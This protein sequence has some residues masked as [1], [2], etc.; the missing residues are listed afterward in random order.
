M[1]AAQLHVTPLSLV[2]IL[3]S[4]ALTACHDPAPERSLEGTW[5][6]RTEWTWDNKGE[7]IP[8]SAVQQAT[9]QDHQVQSTGTLSIG[10]AQTEP[11]EYECDQEER[12]RGRPE[13]KC[14]AGALECDAED[15]RAA[16]S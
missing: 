7:A 3:L 14:V 1:N 10:D 2:L 5:D 11:S 13:H 15:E 4:G 9:S 12:E 8:C 16:C 6:C